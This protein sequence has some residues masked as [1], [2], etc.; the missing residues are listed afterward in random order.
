MKRER[1]TKT[2]K[3]ISIRNPYAHEIMCGIK[4]YEFRTWKTDYRG[5]LL[6]CSSANPKVK[7]TICGHALCIVRLDD[8]VKITRKNYKEFDLDAPPEIDYYAWHL[9]NGRVIKPFPVKGKLNFYEVDDVQIEIIDNGDDS[10]TDAE[11]EELY[12][13][14]I[15]PLLYTGKK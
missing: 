13:K 14:Y 15:E 6:I 3:A 4:E 5:D 10:L 12:T 1:E 7:N 11:A 8:I 2:M 9:T